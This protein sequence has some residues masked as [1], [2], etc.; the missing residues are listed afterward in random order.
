VEHLSQLGTTQLTASPYAFWAASS[1]YTYASTAAWSANVSTAIWADTATWAT[2]AGAL[3]DKI[4]L[5]TIPYSIFVAS[6]AYASTAESV[7]SRDG[8]LA[9]I[10]SSKE[11]LEPG[12]VVVIS[13][14]IDDNNDKK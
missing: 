10:Y 6:S 14:D 5:S 9:E 12:D 1:T 8:Y 4:H 11:N 2:T 3:P 13:Q 7:I